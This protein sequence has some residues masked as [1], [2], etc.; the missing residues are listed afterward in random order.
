MEILIA[1]WKW[2]R[3]ERVFCCVDFSFLQELQSLDKY[4][5]EKRE[6]IND[7]G[8]R[9]SAEMMA[10]DWIGRIVNCCCAE[11]STTAVR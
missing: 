4:E 11:Y 10:T 7:F 9:R 3:L 2:W 6:R 1:T 5:I 8:K